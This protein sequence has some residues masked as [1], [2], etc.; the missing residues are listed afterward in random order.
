MTHSD[1]SNKEEVEEVDPFDM[2]MD[3]IPDA[4]D[5]SNEVAEKTDSEIQIDQMEQLLSSKRC[6][7]WERGFCDSCLLYLKS[8]PNAQLS[9]KQKDVLAKTWD[10]YS[11]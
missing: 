11:L 2:D 3:S 6:N 1:P 10:K 9:Y 5:D 8:K 4:P 7:T